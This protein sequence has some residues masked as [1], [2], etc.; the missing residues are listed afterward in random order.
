MEGLGWIAVGIYASTRFFSRL[1]RRDSLYR[2]RRTVLS[3]HSLRAPEQTKA[4]SRRSPPREERL[5]LWRLPCTELWTEK[6]SN[7]GDSPMSLQRRNSFMV[8]LRD[9]SRNLG[10]RCDRRV[11]GNSVSFGGQ[12]HRRT[13]VT[14]GSGRPRRT[15][16]FG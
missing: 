16:H 9:T 7:S 5:R 3:S 13:I 11:F 6:S 1:E 10:G 8:Q 14:S 15:S 4:N 2:V 12:I